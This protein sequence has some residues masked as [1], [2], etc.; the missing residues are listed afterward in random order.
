MDD[1]RNIVG[2]RER[3][4]VD[5][6]NMAARHARNVVKRID[7]IAREPLE[8]SVRQHGARAFQKFLSR[9]ENEDGRTLKIVPAG[10]IRRRR[11]EGDRMPIVTACVGYAVHLRTIGDRR[12][13]ADRQRIEF[14]TQPDG[15]DVGAFSLPLTK[16]ADDACAANTRRHLE[17]D[18]AQL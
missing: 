5:D 18:V 7:F 4:T 3:S 8:Q 17:A 1:N 10:K 13:F 9:L 6:T 15:A 12:L 2:G 16:D 11:Q 14:G